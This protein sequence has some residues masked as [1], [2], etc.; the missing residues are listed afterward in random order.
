MI[1]V[2]KQTLYLDANAH[3]P[4]NSKALK[5]YVD[6]CNSSAAH[7]HPISP[8]V[9]GRLATTALEEARGKIASLIGAKK[10]G[11]II[12]TSGATQ[13]CEWALEIFFH[14]SEKK[15][16]FNT[17]SSPIEHPA[18]KD[19]YEKL[20]REYYFG[21]PGYLS[22]NSDGIIQIKKHESDFICC[23]YVQNEIGTIQPIKNLKEISTSNYVFS[24]CSQA[25]GKI[26]LNVTEL[27]IDLAVFGAHKFGG[28]GNFGFIYLKNLEDYNTFG[29]GS[30]YFL[31]RTGT[32]DVAGAVATAAALEDAVAT[33]EQRTKNM[34][35]FQSIL[36][37]GLESLGFEIIGK[38]AT[39]S[40]NTTFVYM[41]GK[42]LESVI[43]L[44]EK[45]IHV[46]LGSACGSLH[47]GES[48]LMKRLG[49]KGGVHDFMRISQFGEYGEKEAKHFLKTLEKVL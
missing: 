2:I 4:M 13:A 29:Y 43:K 18:V 16:A 7:G 6:F 14:Q 17:L 49:R 36:E 34:I 19:V 31:D 24:D 47:S 8:S 15:S 3:L 33:L 28:P 37:Q 25:L 1:K 23:L 45:G 9:P 5:A 12:F 10:P 20:H 48:P 41:P 39:R 38:N 30:R 22:V 32:P 44:G 35:E 42:G 11:Q 27:D 46:G 40:P 26:P 21:E